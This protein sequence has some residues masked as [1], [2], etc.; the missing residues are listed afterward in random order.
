MDWGRLTAWNTTSMPPTDGS[1]YGRVH[2][3]SK[4]PL[5]YMNNLERRNI[6]P[7]TRFGFADLIAG[8]HRDFLYRPHVLTSNMLLRNNADNR[9]LIWDW[10][11]MALARPE[12]FCIS[13]TQDQAAFT[14]LALNRSL[15]IVNPNPYEHSNGVCYKCCGGKDAQTFL[16]AISRGAFE[17]VQAPDYDK[18]HPRYSPPTPTPPPPPPRTRNSTCLDGALAPPTRAAPCTIA[19]S[20]IAT[21]YR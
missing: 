9:A 5:C 21:R 10:L 17:V 12:A 7:R 13:H 16:R 8:D 14:I 3:N 11:I 4:S 19:S 6:H 18:L 20:I 15:P 1:V 2:P